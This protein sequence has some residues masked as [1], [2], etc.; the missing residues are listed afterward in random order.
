MPW[1]IKLGTLRRWDADVIERW[2]GEGCPPVRK[3]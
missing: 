1:G 2:I 3:G